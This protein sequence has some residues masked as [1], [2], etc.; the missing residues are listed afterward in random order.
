MLFWSRNLLR[1]KLYHPFFLILRQYRL[2]S[3][4]D[5]HSYERLDTVDLI[6]FKTLFEK[7]LGSVMVAH[8][9]I[10]WINNTSITFPSYYCLTAMPTGCSLGMM[11][12]E[13]PN[14]RCYSINIATT[15]RI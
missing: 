2:R 13:M 9:H 3:Q 6:P 7:G 15:C 4:L 12:K 5:K 1:K 11:M 14:K 8:L 10:P